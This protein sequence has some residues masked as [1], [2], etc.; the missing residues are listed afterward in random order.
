LD[1]TFKQLYVPKRVPVTPVKTYPEGTSPANLIYTT[2]NKKLNF[3][4]Q[5]HPLDT[6]RTLLIP[7]FHLP[8]NG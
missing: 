6:P 3:N 7:S 2:R 4:V 8:E 1:A 5:E